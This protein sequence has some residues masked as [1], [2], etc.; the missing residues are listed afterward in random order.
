M[1][2]DEV[3][4]TVSS[5]VG[6]DGALSFR[7]EKY[8]PRGGPDG[9][10]GGRGGDVIVRANEHIDTLQ[11][12]TSGRHY[13]APHGEG[14]G[15]NLKH[16]ASGEPIVLEV[17]VGTLIRD[18]ERG[19]VLR[20]LDEHGLE[21]V[22]V[23]GGAGGR[24]NKHFAHATNQTPTRITEGK[25]GATRALQLELRLV[26]DVGLVGLPNAG[27]STLLRRLSS[28]RPKVAAYPF[29]TLAPVLGLVDFFD[30]S[31]V[32]ADIPGLI[33]GAHEGAGLG[34]RFLRHIAR[35]RTL[36]HLVSCENGVEA[37]VEGYHTICAEL[38]QSGLGLDTKATVVVVSKTDLM[39]D[40]GEIVAAL[41][42]ASG[43][44]ILAFSSQSGDGIRPL[45]GRLRNLVDE[46]RPRE[47]APARRI[48]PHELGHTDPR[49]EDAG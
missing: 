40:A 16:G 10:D 3:V 49:Q 6:G 34:D 35:T 30:S 24:G 5:G 1:F 21:C 27:K 17:P 43:Q 13:R 44:P 42:A 4:I 38:K 31:L 20:D 41:E 2:I 47:P 23:E 37:A 8:I 19:H 15:S 48:P 14:G 46:A 36:L 18:A 32:M 29:T 12:I 11:A 7:R 45:M 39:P 25:E 33:E 22:I 28:A 9:G 26:A